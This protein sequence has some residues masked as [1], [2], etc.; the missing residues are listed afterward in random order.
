MSATLCV[1]FALLPQGDVR[2]A[3]RVVDLQGRPV[4][5]ATV[6]FLSRS[7]SRSP[8][9]GTEDRREV[10]TDNRG[11]YRIELDRQHR[12]TVWANWEG[13]ASHC[14]EGVSGGEFVELHGAAV[15]GTTAL[16]LPGLDAWPGHETFRVRAVVGGE[17][18]DYV[19]AER[20]EGTWRFPAMPPMGSRAFEVLDPKGEVRWCA[21]FLGAREVAE[22]T[23]P[24]LQRWEVTVV[25]AQDAPI[26]GVALRWHIRNYW[27][28]QSDCLPYGQRFRSLWPVAS[29]TDAEGKATVEVP[30]VHGR[31]DLWM[32][33]VKDGYQMSQFGTKNDNRFAAGKQAPVQPEDPHDPFRVVLQKKEPTVLDFRDGQGRSDIAGW[34]SCGLRVNIKHKGGGFGTIMLLDVPIEDGR[35]VLRAPLPDNTETEVVETRLADAYR[36]ALIAAHGSAPLQWRAVGGG[37]MMMGVVPD[38]PFALRDPVRVQVTSVDGRPAARASVL[39]RAGR[40]STQGVRT[41]RVGKAWLPGGDLKIQTVVAADA[42]GVVVAEI[43]DPEELLNLQLQPF[44]RAR[45]RVVD[46]DG[47]P[48]SGCEV[49]ISSCKVL[50]GD[51]SSEWGFRTLMPYRLPGVTD[52]DGWVQ[53][54]VPPV[55]CELNLRT[56]R[57]IEDGAT[58]T[59]DPDEPGPHSVVVGPPR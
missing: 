36:K 51:K 53:L 1:L 5:N 3:G 41:D 32:V 16:T 50:D 19:F 21:S 40:Y 13:G 11:R 12:Y 23:V 34:L 26:Q 59:W 43:A 48:V 37:Q 28:T 39:F 38:D 58:V 29:T 25:D 20:D 8:D 31:G 44:D 17:N 10:T 18:I 54:A 6:R 7:M 15:P 55:A 45:I 14:L 49:S 24:E 47:K 9:V 57:K 56:P 22:S 4:A 2:S 33:A 30:F 52:A 46:G 27:Y 42:T 35:A